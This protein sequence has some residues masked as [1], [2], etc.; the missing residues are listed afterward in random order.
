MRINVAPH[1]NQGVLR[2]ILIY[3]AVTL[4][5]TSAARADSSTV[6]VF[7]F[8]NL[9]G[10]RTLDWIGEGI[11]ELIIGRLQSEPG[12]YTFSREERLAAYEKFGIPESAMITRATALKLGWSYGLDNI[13]TGTFSGTADDFHILARLV[14]LGAGA[15]TEIRTEGKLQDVIPLTMTLSWQL[16]RKII[17]GTA[18]PESDY[19]ARPPTPRSPFENYI[20]ALLSPDLQRR[21]DLLQTAVRLYPQ[22]GSALFQLGR[23][24]HL[25]RDFAISNEWLQKLPA[26][27]PD[28]RQ[29]LFM[30][31]LN[32]FYLGQY[33]R[34]ITAFQQ[35][36][37]MPDVLLNLGAALSR[38]G[39]MTAAMSMWKRAAS[40]DPLGS[41]AFFNMGYVSYLKN[42]LGA[43]EKNL[44]ESLKLRGRD[45]EALFL[46][47]RT[48][49]K[50]GRS[51]EARKLLSQAARLSE[52]VERWLNQSLPKL[53]RFVTSTTFRSHEDIWSD[54][55]L[56]RRTRSQD[57]ASWLDV[58]QADLDAYLFGEALREL[59]D[60]LKVFPDSSEARS[61]IAEVERQR[62]LR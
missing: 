46:L 39:D 10:D 29:V 6:L 28:R 26:A 5:V 60:V 27:T 62:N 20:R 54:Q 42:D 13:I 23:A 1:Y 14:D 22:Y 48:Y 19:T 58:V 33:E 17:P 50:Q 47:G 32:Y 24:F 35:L 16:L 53:D 7:P 4:A 56:A 34:A 38:K 36:P 44:V 15:G 30:I 3:L 59:R 40:L 43:A 61:L 2:R 41:D 52:R 21:T 51:E 31:G 8:E 55:R 37:Q 9:S 45:S 18:S 12:V 57:L 25:Q 49:E 11:S